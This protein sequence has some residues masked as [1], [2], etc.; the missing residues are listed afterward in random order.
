MNGLLD[1]LSPEARHAFLTEPVHLPGLEPKPGRL[2]M[3]TAGEFLALGDTAPAWTVPSLVPE[4][5]STM[6]NGRPRSFKSLAAEALLVSAALH[7]PVFGRTEWLADRPLRCGWIG[8]EDGAN[9]T[10]ARLRWLLAGHEADPPE[11]LWLCARKGLSL[12][13]PR[14]QADIHAIINDLQLDVVVFDTARALAPSIDKGPADASGAIAFNRALLAETCLRGSIFVAHDTKP[15]R[16]GVDERSRSE[17]ASGGA[18]LAA[19]DCPI[20]FERVSDRE[21]LVVPDRFKT[22]SD[23]APFR[24]TWESATPAGQPFGG[25]LRATAS[26]AAGTD[27]KAAILDDAVVAWVTD[28]AGETQNAVVRGVGRNRLHVTES[29]NRLFKAGRL[30]QAPGPRG[31]ILWIPTVPRNQSGVQ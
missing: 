18:I 28:H 3:Q 4:K 14:G 17:R 6:F 8:E 7:R 27:A 2:L 22:G 31:S 23:P 20:G 16:D 10:G 24:L 25:W 12:E 11:T 29:L 21:A 30:D 5:G 9:L 15:G 13:T 19:M 26:D 1:A